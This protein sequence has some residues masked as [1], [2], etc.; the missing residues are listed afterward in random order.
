MRSQLIAAFRGTL[1]VLLLALFAPL[2]PAATIILVRHA[3]RNEG[4]TPDV[5][6]S[7]KGEERARQLSRVLKDAKIRAVFATEVRRTQQTA[8]P[9][10]RQFHLQTVIIPQKDVN[11]LAAR[12]KAL[13]DDETA[14]VVGHVN[15]LPAVVEQ[16]GGSMTPLAETEYDRLVIVVTAKDRTPTILTLRYGEESH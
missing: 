10:A 16:L 11:A 8:E 2:A 9:T 13:P 5:L 7:P 14:L 15:N 4:M 6:L 1:A 12:L 3:E